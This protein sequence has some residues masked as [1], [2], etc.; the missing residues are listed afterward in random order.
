MDAAAKERP[1]GDDDGTRSKATPV[2]RLD[3]GDA[4]AAFV[5]EQICDHALRELEGR[6]ALEQAA[7]GATVQ[8]AIALR[9][10]SPHG[11]TLGA[12]Q[13]A[14]L[15]C[16]AIGGAAHETPEDIDLAD[17]GALG[18]SANSR[19]AGHLADCVEDGREQQRARA[20]TRGHSCGFGARM[21]GADN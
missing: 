13:H 1:G 20:Q 5:E 17:D 7:H 19:V 12:I 21:T 14:E 16:R 11:G 6:E 4:L 3:S 15:D 8:C 10:R 18:Y 9:A 2:A